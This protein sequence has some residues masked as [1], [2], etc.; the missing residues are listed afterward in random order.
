MN[1]VKKIYYTAEEV[2]QLLGISVSTSYRII[3]QLNKE[4]STKGFIVLAGKLPI[5][6]FEEKYYGYSTTGGNQ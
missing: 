6:Y 3:R 1:E 4:L 5:K 2:S